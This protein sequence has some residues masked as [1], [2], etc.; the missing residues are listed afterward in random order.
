MKKLECKIKHLLPKKKKLIYKQ[1]KIK[2]KKFK[3]NNKKFIKILSIILL[4]PKTFY[5]ILKELSTVCLAVKLNL[6]GIEIIIKLKKI[7]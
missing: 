3:I 5:W 4:N 7:S 2:K 6:F 1:K